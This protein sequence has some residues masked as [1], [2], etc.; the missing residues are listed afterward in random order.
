MEGAGDRR[1]CESRVTSAGGVHELFL[2]AVR[3]VVEG[4]GGLAELGETQ[5]DRENG[6]GH[7]VVKFAADAAAFF[8]LEFEEFGGELVDGAFCVFQVG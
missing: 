1:E 6:L 5:V 2:G 8:V 3:G 7:A 4:L